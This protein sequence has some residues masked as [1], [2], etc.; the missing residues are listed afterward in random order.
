MALR[1]YFRRF[2]HRAGWRAGCLLGLALSAGLVQG[3]GLLMVLPFLEL[4]GQNQGPSNWPVVVE[5]LVEAWPTS[6]IP[7][8][9]FTAL[10]GF[11]L[12]VLLTSSLG[13]ARALVQ[14]RVISDFGRMLRDE[15]YRNLI[16]ARW[17]T[18]A[19]FERG[20]LQQH[21]QQDTRE[22]EGVANTGVALGAGAITG[23][24][25]LG[26][27]I[28]LSLILT[29]FATLA[30]LIIFACLWPVKR[31][32][33]RSALAIRTGVRGVYQ[34]VEERVS[35]I[36]LVKSFGRE[37]HEWREFQRLTEDMRRHRIRSADANAGVPVAYAV[38]GAAFLSVLIYAGVS[39]LGLGGDRVLVLTVIFARLLAIANVVQQ[40]V[41]A[42]ARTAPALQALYQRACDL[43]PE[44]EAFST[45]LENERLKLGDHLRLE[46]VGFRYLDEGAPVLRDISFSIKPGSITALAGPSG[47]GKTTV[48]DLILGL[49]EPTEGRI[50]VDEVTLD[51][52]MRSRWRGAVAYMPQEQLLLHDSIR[53]NLLWANESATEEQMWFALEQASAAGFVRA[54]PEQLETIVGNRGGRFSGGERQRLSLARALMR[55]PSLL[56]LDEPT[57][58]ID[59]ANEATVLKA[60]QTLK[61]S[62]TILL[63]AHSPQAIAVAD[64]VVR[65][66]AGRQVAGS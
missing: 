45:S 63:I 15:L 46:S 42:L 8:N 35:M 11:V 65:L 51:S 39:V 3:V 27:A 30:A 22:V 36:K 9:L 29:A 13:W 52:T 26:V 44:T 62:T 54:L 18:L 47:A 33:E 55:S 12:L 28:Q 21:I 49:L 40:S 56:V 53:A 38:L 19:R 60:L 5:W 7:L 64:S 31:R 24:V 50:I 41:N 2:L 59:D 25:Y 1:H 58:A 4:A 66:E 6:I 14:V 10:C 61:K 34:R 37:H 32:I 57:S 43:Q 23:L 20:E 48:A 17:T 16:A